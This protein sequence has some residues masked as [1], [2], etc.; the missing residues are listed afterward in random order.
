MCLSLTL[1][2]R[3]IR[4]L[5]HKHPS[6]LTDGDRYNKT[7]LHLAALHGRTEVTDVLIHQGAEVDARWEALWLTRF[8]RSS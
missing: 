2:T 8:N 7:P 1:Y 5:A 6:S 4:F 3:V